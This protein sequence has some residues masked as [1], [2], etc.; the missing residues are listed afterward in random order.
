M[1]NVVNKVQITGRIIPR[2][3]ITVDVEFKLRSIRVQW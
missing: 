1:D 2:K 3:Y